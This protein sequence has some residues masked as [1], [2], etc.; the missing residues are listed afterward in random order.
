M[1]RTVLQAPSRDCLNSSNC[2]NVPLFNSICPLGVRETIKPS[3]P[4]KVSET[5]LFV[6]TKWSCHSAV[7]VFSIASLHSYAL[8]LTLVLLY[9]W[10][11][12]LFPTREKLGDNHKGTDMVVVIVVIQLS[13]KRVHC[14][15][16]SFGTPFVTSQY[17][18]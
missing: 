1:W 10:V 15:C 13:Q 6:V 14:H 2:P 18:I 11:N 9:N 4:L 5:S 17:V 12:Y 7:R 16:L 3:V 8:I